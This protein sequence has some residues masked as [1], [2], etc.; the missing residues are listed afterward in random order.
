MLTFSYF[1]SLSVS[2]HKFI[3]KWFIAA[4]Y[5]IICIFNMCV[6]FTLK[7]YIEKADA[8]LSALQI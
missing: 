8:L 6:F 4:A 7:L 3:N 1:Y 5:F 2:S